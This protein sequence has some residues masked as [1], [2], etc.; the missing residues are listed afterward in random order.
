MKMIKDKI[1]NRFC[2]KNAF[3]L[4]EVLITIGIVGTVAAITLPVLIKNYQKQ[5]TVVRLKKAYAELYQAVNMSVNDNTEVE[6]WDYSLTGEEFFLKY[7]GRFTFYYKSYIRI[8]FI[9]RTN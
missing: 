3:T 2:V 9:T 6:N 7:F 1:F 4:A 5:V 8:L